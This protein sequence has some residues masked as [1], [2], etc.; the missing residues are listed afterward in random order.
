MNDEISRV[1]EK[2]AQKR[3][4]VLNPEA[5]AAREHHL[6]KEVVDAEIVAESD[7]ITKRTFK[8]HHRAVIE[9]N[10]SIDT[11]SRTL[12]RSRFDQM[13]MAIADP[14]RVLVLNFLSGLLKGLGFALGAALVAGGV[15]WFWIWS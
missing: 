4:Q 14:S 7:L 2:I 11:L 9:L 8:K 5:M 10:R 13:A 15:L 6:R 3:H 12:D 1:M